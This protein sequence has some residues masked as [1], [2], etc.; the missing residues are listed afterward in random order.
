[1]VLLKEQV[2][3][4]RGMLR[5]CNKWYYMQEALRIQRFKARLQTAIKM[6]QIVEPFI[7]RKA[8]HLQKGRVVIFWCRTGQPYF[9][10]IQEQL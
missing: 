7:V 10:T 5:N 8:R 2:Q 4:I 3:I 9:T 6:E 1:M